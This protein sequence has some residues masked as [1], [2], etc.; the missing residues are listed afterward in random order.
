MPKGAR[1]IQLLQRFVEDEEEK[2]DMK[3]IIQ[4]TP[5]LPK[6]A[7]NIILDANLLAKNERE[8][9]VKQMQLSL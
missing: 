5:K 9:N 1:V 8:E 4:G 3:S 2:T 6:Q 7:S